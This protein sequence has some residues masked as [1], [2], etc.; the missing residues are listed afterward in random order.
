MTPLI[1]LLTD[2]GTRDGYPAAMK[3]VIWSLCPAARLAD[4]T[5]EIAPQD[6]AAG[7]LTLGRVAPYAPPGTIFVAVVDPGV[8]TPRR[9]LAAKL[10]GRF[11]VAPDNGLLSV[12][13]AQAGGA[14]TGQALVQLNRAQFWRQP[15]SPT[16][17]GRDIFAPAAAHL[18]NGVPLVELGDALDDP[19]RLA[20][21]LPRRLPD[22]WQ[23]EVTHVDAFGNLATNLGAAHLPPAGG[24]E[25]R[26]AGERILGVV[27]AFG[28]RPPGTLVALIDSA[29]A[30]CIA[31]VNGSAAAHLGVG[32]GCLVE[33]T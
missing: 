19:L 4:L 24:A 29:G 18:A 3:A 32:V 14:G 9:A 22:G 13:L 5:H 1:F 10:D 20:L 31:R 15:V 28:E 23:G 12:V 8:G 33:V 17:H 25:V 26:I 16:F 27:A 2:F 21:P 6:V 30:L 11:F 7:A